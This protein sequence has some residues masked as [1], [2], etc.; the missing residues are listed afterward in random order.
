MTEIQLAENSRLVNEK[1]FVQTADG[2]ALAGC[3]CP[4]CGR[5]YFPKKRVCA[6]CFVI[7]RMEE[8][9]LSRQGRLYSFTII[10]AGPAG[11]QVPY[12]VGYVDLPEGL[13]VFSPLEGDP[14]ALEIG[15]ELAMS[16]GPIKKQNG[17][18]VIGYKFRP[19]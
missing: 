5:T 14:E 3:R 13:R 10:E 2:L 19:A 11:F 12:A 16:I 18:D 8:V 7:D 4:T 17:V 1:W 6:Q 9:A 15:M